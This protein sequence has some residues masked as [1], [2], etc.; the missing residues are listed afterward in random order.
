MGT[1]SALVMG[2]RWTGSPRMTSTTGARLKGS[3]WTLRR[4]AAVRIREEAHSRRPPMDHLETHIEL[5]TPLPDE[6][7]IFLVNGQR[8]KGAFASSRVAVI[9]NTIAVLDEA[10]IGYQRFKSIPDIGCG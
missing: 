2:A 1:D 5:S 6:E 4:S 3:G 8:D 9:D 7:T 10:G